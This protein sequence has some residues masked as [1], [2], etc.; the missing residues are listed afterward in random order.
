MTEA[1]MFRDKAT[2]CDRLAEAAFTESARQELRQ[3]AAEC[4]RQAE[5][6]ERIAQ[7]RTRRSS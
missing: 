6:L 5:K 3:Q 7:Q 2:R 4:R 1:E